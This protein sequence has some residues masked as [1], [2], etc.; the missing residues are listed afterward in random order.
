[1]VTWLPSSWETRKTVSQR[2]LGLA[3]G[4]QEVLELSLSSIAHPNFSCTF[5]VFSLL[6]LRT[7]Q[8]TL[9]SDVSQREACMASVHWASRAPSC[10]T[11]CPVCIS[12]GWRCSQHV[13]LKA[14]TPEA[15]PGALFSACSLVSSSPLNSISGGPALCFNKSF[16][17]H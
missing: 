8:S 9:D 16:E 2:G 5:P 7:S 10:S 14:A 1:M 13:A 15:L 4:K 17:S 3:S 12:T 11:P 6:I